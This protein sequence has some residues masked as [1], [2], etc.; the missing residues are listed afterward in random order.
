MSYLV[1]LLKRTP[2]EYEHKLTLTNCRC[3]S[4]ENLMFVQEQR[5]YGSCEN[6]YVLSYGK[7]RQQPIAHRE[8]LEEIA[9]LENDL[10]ST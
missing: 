7:M 4:C 9:F 1:E 5:I 3:P 2:K 8:S 10:A 6:C